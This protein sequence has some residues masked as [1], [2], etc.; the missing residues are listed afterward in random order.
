M[1]NSV[2]L[3]SR[4]K[5]RYQ[6]VHIP[7]DVQFL[8]IKQLN[9]TATPYHLLEFSAINKLLTTTT[10]FFFKVNSNLIRTVVARSVLQKRI[11]V[12][13]LYATCPQGLSILKTKANELKKGLLGIVYPFS[14]ILEL[15][16]LGYKVRVL[17]N[18]LIEFKLGLS[19]V[20]LYKLPEDIRVI[21]LGNKNRAFK[22]LGPCKTKLYAIQSRLQR[23]RSPNVYKLKGI[24]PRFV[25][26]T[27]KVGY[28]QSK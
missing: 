21:P 11:I 5:K 18:N 13:Y 23:L 26:P 15:R 22:L 9:D 10:K 25:R 6:I 1:S 19:H 14:C 12:V 16:G 24:F 27:I 3:N 28:K 20:F 2:F 8:S 7:P 4:I 17:S